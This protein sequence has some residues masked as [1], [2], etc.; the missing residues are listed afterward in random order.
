MRR[1]RFLQTAL[2][3]GGLASFQILRGSARGLPGDLPADAAE[4]ALVRARAQSAARGPIIDVHMHAYPADGA[5]DASLTNPVSGKP[6]GLKDGEAH[7]QACLAEMKRLNI[8]KGVVSGGTGDRLGAAMHWHDAAPDR[9]IAGAGV[10][11]S[12]D[13]PLPGLGVLRKAFADRR[14]RVL[15]EVTAEYAGMS[16]SDPRYEAYLALAEEFDIPVALHT[17]TAPPGTSY[18]PC[19]R[20]FR[21]SLGNPLLIEEALNRHPAL[22]VNL[23]HAAWPYLEETLAL[24][25]LYP[26][27]SVDIGALGWGQPR[28]EFYYYLGALMRAGYGKR[29]MFGSDHMYWPD[30]IGITVDAVDSA[31][32]LTP[33]DK[34]D[35]FHDNAVRFYKLE[36]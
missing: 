18:D 22:R 10:R 17:G 36:S 20:N 33:A 34:R 32:F 28:A 23:M 12:D 3:G 9:I 13:T 21:V 25:N 24:L 2:I 26:Q 4:E 1:R 14:L 11:G 16:L 30:L 8:V 35:I 15:G 27:V 29:V 31:P 6:P 19:C 7:M 5:I